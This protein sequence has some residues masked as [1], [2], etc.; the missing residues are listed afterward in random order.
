MT[1]PSAP[2]P[3]A[4]IIKEGVTLPEQ[5]ILTGLSVAGYCALIVPAISPAPYPH[6]Q[7]KNAKIFISPLDLLAN[8]FTSLYLF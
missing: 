1:I 2:L 4:R 3:I 8:Y 5:L 6:F 7:H